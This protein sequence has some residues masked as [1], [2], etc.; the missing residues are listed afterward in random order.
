MKLQV[1]I[2]RSSRATPAPRPGLT[3]AAGPHDAQGTWIHGAL[4][5]PQGESPADPHG[6]LSSIVLVA[7][8]EKNQVP[9]TARLAAATVHPRPWEPVDLGKKPH[10]RAAFSVHSSQLF[11][12]F[13]D[14][15]YLHA[16]AGSLLSP[17]VQL[18][19]GKPTAL[20]AGEPLLAAYD[21]LLLG[22]AAEAAAGFS[23]LVTDAALVAE[24]DSAHRYNAACAAAVASAAQR[25]RDATRAAELA[26]QAR[27]W[28]TGDL[29]LRVQEHARRSFAWQSSRDPEDELDPI[30]EV[31]RGH[32]RF[33][34]ADPDLA[35]LGPDELVQA[36]LASP[37]P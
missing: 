13:V 11:K 31:L 7:I 12:L 6:L 8:S 25:S 32:V 34:L 21:H 3:L 4:V 37:A 10:L 1:P 17:A 19:P 20:P 36:A 29:K 26:R 18:D 5:L 28:L 9:Y 14:R 33:L 2:L 22:R 30:E 35:Q 16:V 23:A 27:D 24:L 15:F